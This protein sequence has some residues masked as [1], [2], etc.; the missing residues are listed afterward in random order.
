MDKVEKLDNFR[1]LENDKDI[2]RVILF[3]KKAKTPPI[4]KVLASVYRD[5][6]RF[7][8]VAAESAGDVV[9]QFSEHIGEQYPSILVLKSWDAKEN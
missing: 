5:R 8:F 1:D 4:F 6:F 2:N 7:G 9:K 3:S